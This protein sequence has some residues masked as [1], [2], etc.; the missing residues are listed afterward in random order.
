MNSND[1]IA[2]KLININDYNILKKI[3]KE[4]DGNV[5]QIIEKKTSQIYAAK[6]LMIANDDEAMKDFFKEIEIILKFDSPFIAKFIGYSLKDFE[7]NP[8]PVIITEFTSNGTLDEVLY[9]EKR[10]NAP[11]EWNGTTKMKVIYGIATAMSHIHSKGII[12]RNLNTSNILLDDYLL[13][14]ISNFAFVTSE[15]YIPNIISPYPIRNALYY[16]PE[17]LREEKYTKASDVYDF[18]F[19]LFEIITGKKPFIERNSHKLKD[20]L[21][22]MHGGRPKFDNNVP[23]SYKELIEKCWADDPNDRPTF[24]EIITLLETEKDFIIDDADED[25]FLVFIEDIK[26]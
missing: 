15:N 6:V 21:Y 2:S 9:K 10:S 17:I 1:I 16:P 23:N 19:V 11:D 22:F 3:Y 8:S 13:P 25:E 7:D 4:F 20:Q 24:D 26:D 12:Y 14:K 5:Y 18:S